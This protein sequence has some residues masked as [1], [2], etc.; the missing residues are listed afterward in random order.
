MKQENTMITEQLLINEIHQ[1]PENLKEEVLKFID[2][3]KFKQQSPNQ[4]TIEAMQSANR[5]EYETVSLNDLK[6]Q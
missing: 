1:L 4:T 5:G 2:F 3:L 6:K